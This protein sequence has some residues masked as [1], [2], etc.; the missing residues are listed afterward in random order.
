MIRSFLRNLLFPIE[1][2]SHRRLGEAAEYNRRWRECRDLLKQVKNGAGAVIAE[3]KTAEEFV[4][5]CYHELRT[6]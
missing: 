5:W 1:A 3:Q 2:A 6:P 4:R